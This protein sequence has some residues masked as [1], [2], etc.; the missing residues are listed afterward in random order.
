MSQEKYHPSPEEIKSATERLEPAEVEMSKRREERENYKKEIGME[1]NLSIEADSLTNK[2][3][4]RFRAIGYDQKRTRGYYPSVAVMKGEINGK[5]VSL[6]RILLPS[7]KVGLNTPIV[8][9]EPDD[10]F[11][12]I[13]QNDGESITLTHGQ[14]KQIYK[15][16]LSAAE[17][18]GDEK[19]L[20][21]IAKQQRDETERKLTEEEKGTGIEDLL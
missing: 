10:A 3:M 15:K 14:A 18:G 6:R 8:D 17:V 21:H 12:G 19:Y 20:S 4:E 1:G 13:V 7:P 2:E 5:A 11:S 16:H 9:N